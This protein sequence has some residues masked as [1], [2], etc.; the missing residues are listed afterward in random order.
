MPRWILPAIPA[1]Y[2]GTASWNARISTLA[3]RIN[4]ALSLPN[5]QGTRY[6]Y[7]FRIDSANNCYIYFANDAWYDAVVAAS[8]GTTIGLTTA[9]QVQNPTAGT[10]G[11]Y[12][13][14]P[15]GDAAAAAAFRPFGIPQGRQQLYVV[16]LG[17]SKTNC[18]FGGLHN[19][20]QKLWAQIHGTVNPVTLT[21]PNSTIGVTSIG[22]DS[23]GTDGSVWAAH[24]CYT[25]DFNLSQSMFSENWGRDSW[26]I[27][28]LDGGNTTQNWLEYGYPNALK[29]LQ[30][31]P[32]QRMVFS[33]W[34]GTNDLST[35]A[36]PCS[37]ADDPVY[38][39]AT[40][41]YDNGLVPLISAIKTDYPSAKI[42]FTV[43][44]ARTTSTNLNGRIASFANKVK[45]AAAAGS[46]AIDY[47]VDLHAF[48]D[49]WG[50]TPF[51]PQMAN[52]TQ[53]FRAIRF[54]PSDVN[55]T[56]NTITA[57]ALGDTIWS[58]GAGNGL[59]ITFIRGT[60]NTGGV[61]PALPSG[62]SAG[63]VYFVGNIQGSTFQVFTNRADALAGSGA[64]LVSL[65][66]QGVIDGATAG[67][68]HRVCFYPYQAD[69]VHDTVPGT[70]QIA[71]LIRQ[72]ILRVV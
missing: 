3:R 26:Q 64:S 38:G 1:G 54:A 6:A 11:T 60:D 7:T 21:S 2:I 9:E 66:S 27:A 44:M 32:N 39:A 36:A 15:T 33:I 40:N 56:T 55:T 35:G 28:N 67:D 20:A 24:W 72:G 61:T 48:V 29:T 16:C 10:V 8:N 65:G 53:L 13:A 4:R 63:V 70:A 22:N 37:V 47:V 17:D 12:T 42:V 57:N 50:Y 45:A 58:T 34:L 14:A 23:G 49:Q 5:S 51:N 59:P 18:G 41:L 25:N 43:P 62:V 68:L 69:F 30:L 46:I 31:A 52:L 71:A 19:N